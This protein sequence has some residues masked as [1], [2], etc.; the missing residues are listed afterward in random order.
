MTYS[1]SGCSAFA[2]ASRSADTLGAA[3]LRELRLPAAPEGEKPVPA[4]RLTLLSAAS[5]SGLLELGIDT[6][7]A[8]DVSLLDTSGG[9][10]AGAFVAGPSLAAPRLAGPALARRA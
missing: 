2:V 7:V 10:A 3:K 4:A 5:T 9:L 6:P 8:M 1:G